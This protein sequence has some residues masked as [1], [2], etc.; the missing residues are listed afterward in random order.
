[1]LHS[2]FNSKRSSKE[3]RPKCHLIL[4]RWNEYYKFLSKKNKDIFITR[5]L[6]F[7]ENI[8]IDSTAQVKMNRN[9]E[10]LIASAFVQLTF[11]FNRYRLRS[12]DKIFV[13]HK[14]YTY[15]GVGLP[16]YGDTNPKT[17]SINMVWK[18]IKKG[19]EINDDSLN[20]AIHEF[21]HA[22]VL[23]NKQRMPLR[24]FFPHK[25]LILYLLASK[26]E[27]HRIRRNEPSIFRGYGATNLMEFFAVSVEVFFEQPHRFSSNNPLLFERLS[28]LLKQDPRKVE[29]PPHL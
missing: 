2:L 27:M 11:G 15:E 21:A 7:L 14:P 28:L 1:M 29:H 16:Y 12:F 10:Y 3:E 9:K 8:K 25:K 6:Y 18:I 4:E 23:D 13:R 26:K 22:L 24:K 17:G 20:L 5:V 19:F